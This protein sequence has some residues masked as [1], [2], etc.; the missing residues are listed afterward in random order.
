VTLAAHGRLGP[1]RLQLEDPQLT[2]GDR[3][4]CDHNAIAQLGAANGSRGAIAALDRALGSEPGEP[5]Q[6]A[7]WWR[8]RA[9]IS[10]AHAEQRTS[11]HT[12]DQQPTA[13]QGPPI[14]R[15]QPDPASARS[16]RAVAAP[17]RSGPPAGSTHEEARH[18]D[19]EP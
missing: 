18:A 7:A 3:V 10:R 12:A 2:A 16:M 8:A 5:A 9:A 1:E 17:A 11:E 19:V 4:V 13:P 14:D 6:R 15:R